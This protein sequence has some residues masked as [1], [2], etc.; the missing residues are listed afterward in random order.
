M[1][2][3]SPPGRLTALP[4]AAVGSVSLIFG[5]ASSPA[6]SD[7][8]L[9]RDVVVPL[10]AI[11]RFFPDITRHTE[12]G[13]NRMAPGSPQAT[14]TVIFESVDGSKKVTISLDRYESAAK[15]SSA[16]RQAVQKSRAVSGYRPVPIPDLGQQTFAGTVTMDRETH[17]GLGARQRKLILGV[18]LAGYDATPGNADKLVALARLQ[19]LAARRADSPR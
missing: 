4:I 15:A 18:T 11:S 19:A 7:F 17:I 14:R 1:D 13:R 6:A 10:S 9:A 2:R 8:L 5:S 12:T 16:Y 3:R